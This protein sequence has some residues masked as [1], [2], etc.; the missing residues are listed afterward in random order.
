MI[1][2]KTLTL[3]VLPLALARLPPGLVGVTPLADVGL[4][5]EKVSFPLLVAPSFEA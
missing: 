1:V 5:L 4:V 2:M 3:V